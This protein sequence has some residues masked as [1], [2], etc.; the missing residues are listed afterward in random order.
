[1]EKYG[2]LLN[3]IERMISERSDGIEVSRE[4]NDQFWEDL[5]AHKK[6][7]EE[8]ITRTQQFEGKPEFQSEI[9]N[10]DSIYEAARNYISKYE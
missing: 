10:A 7:M 9:Q 1:M 8:Q 4:I 3:D 6:R 5:G 2:K